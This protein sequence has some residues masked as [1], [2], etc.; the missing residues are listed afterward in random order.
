M[1]S[2]IAHE[3]AAITSEM[4]GRRETYL[5]DTIEEAVQ[6][7]LYTKR[8]KDGSAHVGESGLVVYCGGLGYMVTPPPVSSD[9]VGRGIELAV[10]YQGWQK[11]E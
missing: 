11:G 1:P 10:S 9:T 2:F 6:A 7:L 8:L 5:A 3:F 4:T